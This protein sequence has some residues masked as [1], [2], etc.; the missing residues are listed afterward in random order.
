ML[1]TL[2]EGH[3]Q[4]E[5]QI[6]ALFHFILI[7]AALLVQHHPPYRRLSVYFKI[8][9]IQTTAQVYCL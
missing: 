7:V 4:K 6:G 5:P 1:W 3:I 9:V 2:L 8:N